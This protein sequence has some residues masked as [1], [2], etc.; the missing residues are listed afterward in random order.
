[1]KQPKSLQTILNE[2]QQAEAPNE[3]PSLEPKNRPD[4][5]KGKKILQGWYP[6]EV[7]RQVRLIAADKGTSIERVI[8]DAL[9]L[10][11]EKNGKPPLA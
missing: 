8:G 11:F 1:M 3:T 10:L 7:H 4:S 5:R 2:K 9:N 6:S